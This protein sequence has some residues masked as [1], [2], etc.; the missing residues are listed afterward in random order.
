VYR[1]RP[2]TSNDPPGRTARKLIALAEKHGSFRT[3]DV[4]RRFGHA[5]WVAVD[6]LVYAEYLTR[7]DRNTYAR[8]PRELEDAS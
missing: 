7:I 2:W 8:G 4:N 5:A 3:P 1:E 6:R